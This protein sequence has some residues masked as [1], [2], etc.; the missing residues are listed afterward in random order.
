MILGAF[1]AAL[2][3]LTFA[4]NNAAMRRGVI[5][6][7]VMQGMALTV[8]IGGIAFL[9]MAGV[10]GHL[11][12]IPAFPAVAF[13]WLVTQGIVHFVVGRY[14]N[15]RANQLMGVNLSA[16]VVQLQVPVT[17]LFAV[18]LMHERFTVLQAIGSALMLGGSFTTQRNAVAP[19]APKRSVNAAVASEVTADVFTPRI[20]TGYLFG[21]GAACC[22]GASPLMVRTAFLDAPHTSTAAAGCIA[23]GSAVVL[24]ALMMLWPPALADV[25]AMKRGNFGWFLASGVLVSVSQAFV[26]ASLAVAPLLVVTPILQLSLIFR[27]ILSQIINREHEVLNAY[28]IAGAIT[29]VTG[30]LLVSIDTGYLAAHLPAALGQ[31]LSYRLAGH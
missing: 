26:Y 23:Y 6:G 21:L 20:V 29:A 14:C 5:S 7:T 18:L 16:P 13:S 4:L 1:Y 8:P 27:L 9:L 10:S 28:V 2:G 12:E 22:Y 17:L 31:A 15:Y 24:F 25:R 3:A 30:S 11:G 19:S